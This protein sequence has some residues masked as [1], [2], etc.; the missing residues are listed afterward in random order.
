MQIDTGKSFEE[1]IDRILTKEDNNPEY[2][3]EF[4]YDICKENLLKEVEEDFIYQ[5][6]PGKNY[7]WLKKIL[8]IQYQFLVKYWV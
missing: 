8:M 6:E 1:N 5:N 2:D 3:N 4:D 7:C